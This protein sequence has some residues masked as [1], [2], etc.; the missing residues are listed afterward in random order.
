MTAILKCLQL[1]AYFFCRISYSINVHV[2]WDA[3]RCL[4]WKRVLVYLYRTPITSP[5]LRHCLRWFAFHS[6]L[7][8]RGQKFY[9]AI[10]RF[11]WKRLSPAQQTIWGNESVEQVQQTSACFRC[12]RYL[13]SSPAP[14]TPIL[15]CAVEPGTSA[16]KNPVLLFGFTTKGVTLTRAT[17]NS[18]NTEL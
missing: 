18:S 5:F 8:H 4:R 11:F 1:D 9:D 13:Q 16:S 7:I 3:V 17:A 15:I 12:C 14:S 6:R 10:A 2:V